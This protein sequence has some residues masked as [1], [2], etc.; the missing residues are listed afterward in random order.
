MLGRGGATDA[1]GF[2]ITLAGVDGVAG[3]VD[4]GV[5]DGDAAALAGVA[6]G[7][8]PVSSCTCVGRTKRP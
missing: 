3:G 8:S 1:L 7:A 2:G 6:G 4:A 5:D